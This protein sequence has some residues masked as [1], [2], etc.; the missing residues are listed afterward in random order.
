MHPSFFHMFA[1]LLFPMFFFDTELK[2]A[3]KRR[4]GESGGGGDGDEEGGES[5]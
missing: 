3:R 5:R 1:C 4:M 2:V